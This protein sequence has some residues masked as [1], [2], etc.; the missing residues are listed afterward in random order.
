MSQRGPDVNYIVLDLEWN[1]PLDQGAL[2][3]DPVC[4]NGEII[5]LGAVKLNEQFAVVDEFCMYVQP[6]Y[7]PKLHN[8]I[9]ALTGISDKTLAEKGVS[10]PEMYDCFMQWCGDEYT[11]VTWSMSDLPILI[12]NLIIHQMDLS[13]LPVCYDIQ[14]IFSREIMRGN[15]RYSL[16]TA[17]SILKEHGD[18]SHDALHDARN[19]AKVCDHLDLE[20]YL[21]EYASQVFA[22]RPS[23]TIYD[24]RQDIRDDPTL[25]Q[26]LCPWC[27]E[28]V[29]CEPWISY[30]GNTFAGYGLCPREDE[31]LVE[32]SIVRRPDGR[33]SAKR[34]IY[35]MSDDLWD[36]Y[37]DKK[38]ALG[39]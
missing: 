15:T 26:F 9:V 5:Q 10:F 31:F 22:E 23:Q 38:E 14:R 30:Q 21:N 8:R 36:V 12:D 6:Q 4:L 25:R 7:Y 3:T 18:T 13:G 32:L 37:M 27:G 39:V 19:T 16:E 17:L 2:V 35:E 24:T 11:F 1:Q 33:F 20:L 29:T 28:A 34:T